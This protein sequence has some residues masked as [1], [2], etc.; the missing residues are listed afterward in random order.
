MPK[1]LIPGLVIPAVCIILG[2]SCTS[3]GEAKALDSTNAARR[4]V[5]L[6]PQ[7]GHSFAVSSVAYSPN[8]RFIVSGS[9]DSTVKIWSLETGREIWTLPEHDSMVKSVSYSPDGRFIASGSADNTIKIWGVENGEDLKTLSGH[10]SVVN[11]IAYSPDGR[12]LV[13]GSSDRTIKIWDIESAKV[14]QT[15][16]G[17]SLWI[18]SV[19]YSPDGRTIASGSRDNTVKL[20]NAETGRELRTLSGHTDEVD[21]LRWSPDGKFIATG[22][23]DN[24]I[25]IWDAG[26]GREL[27]TLTGHTG[28]VRT[29]DYSPDGKFIASGSSVDSTIRIWDAAT[30][31]ELRSFGSTGIETLSYSPNGRFIASGCL[32]NTIRLWEASTGRETLSLVGRS[33]WVRAL[34]YSAD[35]RYIASGS[36][37]RTVRIRETGSGRET[38][39]IPGHTASVRAVAYSPDGKYVASG[40]ADS[41]IRIWDAASGRELQILL[42]HSSIV[43]SVAYSPDGQYLISGSSDATI[44]VWEPLSGKERWTFTGHSDGVNSVAYSPDGTNIISGAADNTIKIWNVASGSASATLQ[45]HTS[46]I[47]SL[48]YSPNGRHI[49]SGSMDGTLRVWDAEGGKGIWTSPGYSDHIKSGLAYSPNGRFIAAA[50]KDKTIG[51]FDAETGRKLRNLSGHTGEVYDLVYNPKGLLLVSASLDG[52]TR[53]WDTTTGREI[54]QSISFNDG[55]WISITP[56]GYYTASIKGDRYFNVRVGKDVYGLELYRPAFYNPSIVRTRLQGRKIRNSRSLHNI[57]TFGIPPAL[58][59]NFVARLSVRASDQNFPLQSFRVYLNDKLIG[60]DKMGGLAGPGLKTAPEGINV[61]GKLKEAEFE[62]PLDLDAGT[63]RIDVTVF[64]GHTEGRASLTVERPQG[65]KKEEALPNLRILSIGVSRYDEPRI[66]HLGF[67]VF[68]AREMVNAFKAQ[69][70]KLYGTVTGALIAT[71]ELQPP[72]KNNIT[73]E[74]GNFF[75]GVSSQDTVILFLS[76]HAVNDDDGNYYFLPSD[77]RLTPD[78]SIPYAEALSWETIAAALDVPGRKLLF[79]DSSHSAGVS[80]GNIR[81]VDTTRLAVDLKPLRS[82]LFTSSRGD[83]LSLESIDYK[84]GLFTYAIIEGMNG[85]ADLNKNALI[86]MRELDSFVS[87]KVLALSNGTQHPSIIGLE[88]YAEFNLA[89]T[90]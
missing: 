4:W 72:T 42:G 55:E 10:T 82:L 14:L 78:G 45:G 51:I 41:S 38:L 39:T 3:S 50:L 17:H 8:G 5:E 84:L 19:S 74:L 2:I 69:E 32:D 86:S 62:L 33:S 57:N 60:A 13:S 6:F 36:T 22:S 73:R 7:R 58:S 53:T 34:A 64:N 48:S 28:V 15:L 40:A 29:L 26:N 23:S 46:P 37:D 21:A 18:N 80:A 27:R 16:S 56:D 77:I 63:N 61:T 76:G 31:A 30:G 12:F 83:E 43:K 47:I 90:K 68:D 65:S 85:E 11:S 9:A 81:P 44:K 67:A 88:D 71:G 75:K 87:K 70:G 89:G 25:K 54:T 59:I 24:T 35:G 79:I 66:N 1:R 52:T 20:W 49:A